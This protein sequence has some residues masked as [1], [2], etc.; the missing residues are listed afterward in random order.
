VHGPRGLSCGDRAGIV[1]AIE[2]RI[3]AQRVLKELDVGHAA[4]VWTKLSGMLEASD[5][6]D[7][8]ELYHYDAL[9]LEPYNPTHNGNLLI[10]AYIKDYLA[11]KDD[12]A[13][14]E[15]RVIESEDGRH[16]AV[17]WTI[18]YDAGGRR[19]N[20]LPRATMLEFDDDGLI[21]YHRDYT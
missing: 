17:E 10:Q 14:D 16:L 9:Y 1:G 19:W 3:R 15:K 4:D 5:V 21:V 6:D 18:S 8:G 2:H 13:V 11:G 7:L 12:I 20:E